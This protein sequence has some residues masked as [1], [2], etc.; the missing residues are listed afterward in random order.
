MRPRTA[1]PAV[2]LQVKLNRLKC[3]PI[4]LGRGVKG[5]CDGAERGVSQ[6]ERGGL[7]KIG[8]A[9]RANEHQSMPVHCQWR[10]IER[11]IESG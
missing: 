5:I 2:C 10:E 6:L 1:L 4:R 9:C 3:P 7:L 11:G 8:L